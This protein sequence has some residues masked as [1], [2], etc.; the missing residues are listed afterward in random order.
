MYICEI[1]VESWANNFSAKRYF[2][3]VQ[4][5]TGQYSIETKS[6]MDHLVYYTTEIF[7]KG[8]FQAL[9]GDPELQVIQNT[10]KEK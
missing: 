3:I 8:V 2:Y 4:R 6:G 5:K 10:T 1:K 9:Y 7:G